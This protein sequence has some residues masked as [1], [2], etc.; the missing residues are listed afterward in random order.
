MQ[1]NEPDAEIL[2]VENGSTDN[3]SE[4]VSCITGVRLLHSEKGVSRARNLG[5]KEAT[6]EWIAFLDADDIWF[7]SDQYEFKE[8]ITFFYYYK[9]HELIQLNY[10]GE[11]ALIWALTR[12][13]LRMTVWAKVFRKSFLLDNQLF[14][15]ENLWVSE[16][17]EFLIRA[18]KKSKGSGVSDRA[19]YCYTSDSSSV[20]RSINEKRTLAYLESLQTASGS[21]DEANREE[22]NAFND[23][24]YAHINLIGVHDIYNCE[25]TGKWLSRN[26]KMKE[27]VKSEVIRNALGDL[28]FKDIRNIQR[29]PSWLFKTHAFSAGGFICYIRSKQNA[30]RVKG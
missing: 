30:K 23:Y 8:D 2:V 22:K 12:P 13:T 20:M 7:G 19:L 14:F 18:L 29:L 28:S 3:T 21:I 16:D 26:R 9:D 27:L 6:G 1:T 24:V 17:S 11:D 25:I 15:D 4:V 10:N 5:V